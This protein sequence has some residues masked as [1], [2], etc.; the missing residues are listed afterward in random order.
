MLFRRR[1]IFERCASSITQVR[2]SI[3]LVNVT[4]RANAPERASIDTLRDL[5]LIGL[6]GQSVPLGAVAM[7]RYEIRAA[8]D[9]APNA[10]SNH[11]AEGERPRHRAAE[12]DRG[13][14]RAEG[15]R[16]RKGTAGWILGRDR[17]LGRRKR[18]EP[19]PD[20]SG[21]SA[22]A[23][24]H[25]DDPDDTATK[26]PPAVPGV[27]AAHLSPIPAASESLISASSSLAS[28]RPPADANPG[29]V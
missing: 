14:T 21:R 2:D 28:R 15:G 7:L 8:D 29:N 12:D 10:D 11:H 23:L 25:G 16:V 20:R 13:S 18:E 9:L 27:P 24:R 3:Y 17:G 6:G 26:L 19:G 22:D 4:G 1:C 5:Q